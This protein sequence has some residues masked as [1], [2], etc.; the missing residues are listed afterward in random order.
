MSPH[1]TNM[2]TATATQVAQPMPYNQPVPLDS[3][4]IIAANSF[5]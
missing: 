2:L 4:A 3:H 1:N 5:R